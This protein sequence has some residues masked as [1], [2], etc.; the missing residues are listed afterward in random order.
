[1][2][3]DVCLEFCGLFANPEKLLEGKVP[4]ESPYKSLRTVTAGP[5]PRGH[6]GRG[7]LGRRPDECG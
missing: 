4:D 7:W 2:Y 6:G 3:P 1:M 5:L